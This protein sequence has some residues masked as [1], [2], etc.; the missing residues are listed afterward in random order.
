MTRK[1]LVFQHVPHEVSGTFDPL[2]KQVGVRIKY[3]NFSRQKEVKLNLDSYEGIIILGGPMNVEDSD[4]YPHLTQEIEWIKK[5]LEKDLFIL[6]IC[7]GAQL[8]SKALGGEVT[9]NSVK[10]IG[11]YDV[12]LTEAG[13]KDPFFQYFKN[14]EKI[15]QWHGNTFSIPE[16]CVHLAHSKTCRNQAFKYG[17]RV[18]GVQFHLEVSRALIERWLDLE[19]NGEELL[20][21]KNDIDVDL[22]RN[23]TEKHISELSQLSE[24]TFSSFIEFVGVQGKKI[25]LT[26]R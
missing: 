1:V 26:S 15:F 22:I 23:E 20:K 17:N 14:V 10:E 18:Y 24:K 9:K 16:S 5:A 11:W 7:L 19:F 13:K 2:L 21:H 8:L 25:K 4:R 12:A 6:G 3:V